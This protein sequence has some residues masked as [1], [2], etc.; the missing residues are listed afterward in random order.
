MVGTLT[1]VAYVIVEPCVDVKDGECAVVCP[2]E[3]IYEGGRMFYIQ[4]DEC[5]VCA[6]RVSV[7]RVESIVDAA[8]VPAATAAY[9]D[10][11]REFIDDAATGW[12]ATGG[13]SAALDLDHPVVAQIPP[14]AAS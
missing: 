1:R 13:R 8:E 11:N 14:R 4:P 7:C 12:G 3:C 6:P 10:A 9:V 2:V 5:L